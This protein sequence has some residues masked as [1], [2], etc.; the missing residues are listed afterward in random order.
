[1]MFLVDIDITSNSL[2]PYKRK[3]IWANLKG[4]IYNMYFDEFIEQVTF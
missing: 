4:G 1:M 3:A 2:F